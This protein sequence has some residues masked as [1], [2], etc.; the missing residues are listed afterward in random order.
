MFILSVPQVTGV[1]AAPKFVLIRLVFWLFLFL[2]TLKYGLSV[3]VVDVR[4]R[5]R[6]VPAGVRKSFALSVDG[7]TSKSIST[8]FSPLNGK[9]LF[10]YA[11]CITRSVCNQL[12][13]CAF[14]DPV[15]FTLL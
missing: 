2:L 9:S 7:Q 1:S 3:S 13:T 5:R 8:P 11:Y 4:L 10:S 12:V 6:R 15:T 14:D